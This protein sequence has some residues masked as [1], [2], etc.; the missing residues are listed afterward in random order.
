MK[1]CSRCGVQLATTDFHAD[2]SRRDGLANRCK[3]CQSAHCKAH[4]KKHGQAVR[5]ARKA[6]AA[7]KG[8]QLAAKRADAVRELSDA[9]VRKQLLKGTNL[10][11]HQLTAQLVEMKREAMSLH[12]LAKHMEQALKETEGL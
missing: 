7:I 3:S 1:T 6:Y 4:Y 10:K 12:R 2:A 11:A 9:Y 8:G 5:E